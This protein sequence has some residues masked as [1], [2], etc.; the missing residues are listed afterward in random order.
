MQPAKRDQLESFISDSKCVSCTV[1]KDNL[2][3]SES[4][5]TRLQ[6]EIDQLTLLRVRLSEEIVKSRADAVSV[7]ISANQKFAASNSTVSLLKESR[8]EIASLRAI[9]GGFRESLRIILSVDN[10]DALRSYL[11]G[12]YSS[13]AV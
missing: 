4:E 8:K 5:V 13:C 7:S 10:L 9:I 1:L 12:L 11:R 2:S 6:C 3:N